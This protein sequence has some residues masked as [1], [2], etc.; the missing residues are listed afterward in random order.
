LHCPVFLLAGRDDDVVAREQ[1][2]ASECLIDSCRCTVQKIVAPCGHLGLFMDKAILA[3]VW[4]GIARWLSRQERAESPRAF[5]A[6]LA[7]VDFRRQTRRDLK[8]AARTIR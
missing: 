7:V 5:V 2:F 4:P 1:I 3:E 8:R 6:A